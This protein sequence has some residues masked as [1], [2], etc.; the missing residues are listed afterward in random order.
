MRFT[1]HFSDGKLLKGTDIK[2]Y[3]A[4]RYLTMRNGK[5]YRHLLFLHKLVA[6]YFVPRNSPDEVWV[7]HLDHNKANN[8]ESNLKWFTYEGKVM[9]HKNN[10]GLLIS[11]EKLIARNRSLQHAKLTETQVQH[12]KKIIFNPNRKTRMKM[13]AKRFGIS[14]MQ[15]YR[16]K[17]GENWGHV[18]P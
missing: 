8:H 9:H 7:L 15:L 17:S 12:I 1:N 2:G 3:K 6:E 4:Y 18:K 16:I 13:I 11:R 14:E 10:P 5:E